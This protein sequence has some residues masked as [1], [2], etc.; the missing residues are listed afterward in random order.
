MDIDIA[1][2]TETHLKQKHSSEVVSIQGYC[3]HR[4]DR[5]GPRGGGV[6]IYIKDPISG[7]VINF[8]DCI[9]NYELL[10]ITCKHRNLTLAVGALYHPPNPVYDTKTF[11]AFVEQSVE[12]LAEATDFII[13]AGDF[14]SITPDQI[15]PITGLTNLIKAPTRGENQLDYLFSSPGLF[16]NIK[17]VK[18][19]ATTDHSAVIA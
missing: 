14:N 9:K 16:G 19:M 3:L 17:V 7:T 15:T 4:R 18:S 12:S 10:W 5:I 2:I 8:Q 1:V 6:T 13:L 11:M